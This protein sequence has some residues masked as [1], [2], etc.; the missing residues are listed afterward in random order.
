MR[1]PY[2]EADFYSLRMEGQVYVDRSD[3]IA[4]FADLGKRVLFLRPRRFGKSLWLSTLA[5]YHDLRFADDH[6]RL[7]GDLAISRHPSPPPAHRHFVL[8]WDFSDIDPAPPQRGVNTGIESRSQRLANE[9]HRHILGSLELFLSRYREHLPVEVEL[10]DDAFTALNRT[11]AAIEQTPYRLYLLIDEYDNFV[12]EVLTADEATYE[13]LVTSDGPFKRLFKWVKAAMGSGNGLDRLFITGVSPLV[14]SDVTSGLNISKSVYLDPGLN[15]L[16]GFTGLEVRRLLEDLHAEQAAQGSAPWQVEETAVVMRDW[17]NGYRFAPDAEEAVYNP[18]LVF[19]FIEHLQRTGQY[20]GQMLDSNLAA[21]ERRLGYVARA[22]GAQDTV[23]DLVRQ[24]QPLE[25]SQI[26]DR[27]KLHTLREDAER[28]ASF[29]GSYLYYL[30]MLT[31]ASG[32]TPTR[33]LMLVVPNEVTRGLYLERVREILVPSASQRT[34]DKLRNDFWRDGDL[35]PILDFIETTLFP[36]FSNRDATWANELTVKTA[37]MTLLWNEAAYILHSE[38]ELD[39]RYADLCLL[40]RPDARSSELWDLL[41]EFKRLPLKKLKM[42]GEEVRALSREE[43]MKND[44]VHKALIDANSQL[45]A[46]K[47]ALEKKLGGT[48]RLRSYAVVA[49]GF[50]RLVVQ[51]G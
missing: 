40:R 37:F 46:Y 2:G 24:E 13:E 48:L 42:S 7:F 50:E 34:L 31:L 21:D 36:T 8:R 16:C 10:S 23:V 15:D 25:V 18:T 47:A 20:P 35:L 32:R 27:F 9:I 45:A 19:Y 41:F 51:L 12:N 17:Y 29:L 11:L 6:Q 49:L 22:I 38:P 30:G 1:I 43:L 3:R 26:F 28:G 14:L 5:A 39:H 44:L 4:T 33:N